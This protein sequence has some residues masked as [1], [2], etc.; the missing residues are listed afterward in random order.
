MWVRFRRSGDDLVSVRDDSPVARVADSL[1]LLSDA[2]ARCF[3]VHGEP[4]AVLAAFAKEW[5]FPTAG[6][7]PP[8]PR[9]FSAWRARLRTADDLRRRA[10]LELYAMM[11]MRTELRRMFVERPPSTASELQHA[12]DATAA[13]GRYRDSAEQWRKAIHGSTPLDRARR[14]QHVASCWWREGRLLKAYRHL[15]R[16]LVHAERAGVTGEP[17]W[18]LAAITAHVFGHMRRR[19]LLRFFPTA[20]RRRFGSSRPATRT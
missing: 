18:H 5:G 12:A 1:K 14:E 10:S 7:M 17:L 6:L 15:R 20:G 8:P 13:D 9:C 4:R 3:D 2:G 11:G 19:P 16:E